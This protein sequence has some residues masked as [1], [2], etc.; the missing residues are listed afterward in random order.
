M[1][2]ENS[3]G[4]TEGCPGHDAL[5]DYVA[6]KLPSW[7]LQ[8]LA[9]HIDDCEWCRSSLEEIQVETK[10]NDSL[11]GK[12][13]ECV[14]GEAAAAD[15]P[16]VARLP[17]AS[18]VS[19]QATLTAEVRPP[20]TEL[21]RFFGRFELLQQI[22]EG[23][24]GVVYKA[25]HPGLDRVVALKMIRAGNSAGPQEQQRFRTEGK[26]MGRMNHAHVVEVHDIADVNGQLYLCME[27]VEG[28][29]L[30]DRLQGKGLPVRE[31]AQLVRKL[32]EAVQAAHERNIIH[33]DLKPANVL[34]TAA[35][36]PKISD[37]GLAKLQ[38]TDASHTATD[39]VMGTTCY[40]APEQAAGRIKEVGRLADVY[41]L[42]AILYEALTGQP[43]FR[44]STKV[45]TMDLVRNAEPIWPR[46]LRPEIPRELEAICLACLAKNPADRYPS[47][48]A[49][50]LELDRWLTG[51]PTHARPLPL[52][53]LLW[54]WLPKRIAS[55]A[56]VIVATATFLAFYPKLTK[57]D[58]EAPLKQI[59]ANLAKGQKVTLIGPTGRPN[60]LNV[61]TGA[62]E[63]QTSLARDGAFWINSWGRACVELVR[64]PRMESFRISADIRHEK[65]DLVGEVGLFCSMAEYPLSEHTAYYF[66][67]VAFDDIKDAKEEFSRIPF[68]PNSER[69]KGPEINPV[70][71]SPRIHWVGKGAPFDAR[72]GNETHPDIFEAA[73]AR[74]NGQPWRHI[75]FDVTP[76]GVRATF[77]ADE[78][79]E[80]IALGELSAREMNR[81]TAY[82]L[83]LRREKHLPG[84]FPGAIN[85]EFE[86]RR[87]CG[88]YVNNSAASFRNVVIE[89]ILE[90][91]EN[92]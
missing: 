33:R 18:T 75:T 14:A 39:V 50:A 2:S 60:W 78:E 40:M 72:I 56:L 15:P 73:L 70:F 62:D 79:H 42:G 6:G 38:D 24:M 16:A 69:P 44:A 27:F 37:F 68:P 9:S 48:Q 47:A 23:A 49:L 45:E 67:R 46:R 61:R 54:R 10:D 76:N 31:A 51:K 53:A 12:L 92:P 83:K 81:D 63:T 32:A 88:V 3:S 74:A 90:K 89:P 8:N 36:E 1:L 5:A 22:G 58:P 19:M 29:S 13:R 30:A 34:L 86:P 59:E 41:S 84:P 80:P 11:V 20:R 55:A 66:V 25:W 35:G 17:G 28:G 57:T 91:V 7:A 65:G 43:P 64:D 21:G 4:P 52:Y 85:P 71:L 26:A 82:I 77:Q 87:P